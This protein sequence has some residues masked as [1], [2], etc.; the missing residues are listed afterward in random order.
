MPNSTDI[1]QIVQQFKNV[2]LAVGFWWVRLLLYVSRLAAEPSPGSDWESWQ[3]KP[4]QEWV[5]LLTVWKSHPQS[6]K[7]GKNCTFYW[8]HYECNCSN[9]ADILLFQNFHL[10]FLRHHLDASKSP[11]KSHQAIEMKAQY[12][13]FNCLNSIVLAGRGCSCR[14]LRCSSI[15]RSFCAFQQTVIDSWVEVTITLKPSRN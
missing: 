11:Q 6:P 9:V 14:F 12:G 10:G 8:S 1:F 4:L 7:S 5:E 3:L 15:D 2:L 13:I